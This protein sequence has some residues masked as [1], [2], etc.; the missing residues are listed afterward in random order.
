MVTGS[1][2]DYV[3]LAMH[4][5]E[6][7]DSP[8]PDQIAPDAPEPEP[9]AP[10]RDRPE[11]D[12]PAQVPQPQGPVALLTGA[13]NG[14]GWGLAERLYAAGYRLV[15][16]DLDGEA[17]LRRANAAAW[18]TGLL[19]LEELDVRDPAAWEALL[20][21]TIARWGRIDLLINCA[22]WLQAGWVHE[23]VPD[24][25]DS[26]LD[27]N[28]KGALLGTCLVAR[29]MVRQRAG[30]VVNLASLAGVAPVPGMS[31]YSGSKFAVRGF[32]LAAR[33]ELREHGVAVTVVCTDAVDTDLLAAQLDSDEAALAFSRGRS[34]TVAEMTDQIMRRAVLKRPA[35]LNLPGS[36]G[37]LAKLLGALPTATAP[38][39]RRLQAR[40]ERNQAALRARRPPPPEEQPTP[41]EPPVATAP[42]E[43]ATDEAAT[44][45][46]GPAGGRQ[47]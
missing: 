37:W 43:A 39:L 45:E 24:Q 36:R 32:S 33:E 2:V 5:P 11:R 6:H 40:G 3:P 15:V 19:R 46:A 42:D 44:D 35:E 38:V 29:H 7:G 14:I 21:A 34:S 8:Q 13:A 22:G 28:A 18:V 20:D 1:S 26:H 16:T 12:E 30:H 31:L 27:V 23:V 10:A 25:V 41:V 9:H 47:G 17:L 4:A